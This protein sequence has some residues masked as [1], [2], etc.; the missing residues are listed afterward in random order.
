MV[1]PIPKRA[2]GY[3]RGQ[4]DAPIQ[5]AAFIDIECPLSKKAWSTLLSVAK[6]HSDDQI[7]ITVHPVVL[8]EH[9]QSWDVTK[10]AVILSAGDSIKF[11]DV[12]TYLYDRQEEYSSDVLNQQTHVDLYNLLA[13]FADDYANWRD[14]TAFI[15]Q[16]KS[17][18][19][20]QET[21]IPIRFAISQGVWSTPTFF[22]N[23]GEASQLSSS[24]TLADWKAVFDSMLT[25]E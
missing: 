7:S 16:L 10:A 5:I 15:K 21:K 4:C 25:Q 9:R 17:D 11:W 6:S 14:G 12:L 22:I 3:R 19:I 23:G 8:A 18:E 1:I 24:S 2:S 13:R 20:E